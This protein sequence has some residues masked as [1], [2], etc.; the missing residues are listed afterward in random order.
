MQSKFFLSYLILT[1]SWRSKKQKSLPYHT[2][3]SVTSSKSLIVLRSR[4][5]ET[6]FV[7]HQSTQDQN[8]PRYNRCRAAISVLDWCGSSPLQCSLKRGQPFT[9]KRCGQSFPLILCCSG[10]N[11]ASLPDLLWK[12]CRRGV[13]HS[14][15]VAS[16]A[17][18][19]CYW[20]SWSLTPD[21]I[22]SESPPATSRSR[23]GPNSTIQ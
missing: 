22:K 11:Q 5:R 16:W 9:G 13:M 19:Q 20:D 17:R 21:S 7:S 18:T 14:K 3:P 12:P 8:C 2:I 23:P 4:S 1:L 6:P 10:V 15:Q